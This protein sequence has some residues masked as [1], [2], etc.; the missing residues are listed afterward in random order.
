MSY[1][2]KCGKEVND[3]S[4]YCPSCGAAVSGPSQN[5][6]Y[7]Q[8][9]YNQQNYNQQNY[10]NA[11]PQSQG[12]GGTLTIILVL[13]ILWALYA[14]IYGAVYLA[15]GGVFIEYGGAFA[16]IFGVLAVLSGIFALITCV[17]IYKQ[18]KFKEAFTFILVGSV[19]AI[20]AYPVSFVIL[21]VIGIV[22]A[23]LLKKEQYKFK[24]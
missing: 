19:L 12:L 7:N 3:G 1:C 14:I 18:E 21:G 2:S 9:N 15:V 23:F 6:N 17:Y 22:F 4:A 5:Q 11:P 20:V 24:S 16:I 10:N 8:Q 13:G